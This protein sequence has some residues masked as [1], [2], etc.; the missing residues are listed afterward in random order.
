MCAG[1]LLAVSGIW[2]G[3]LADRNGDV[4]DLS[5]RFTQSGDAVTGKM[6]GDNE[7]TPISEGKISGQQMTFSV[8]SELNGQITTFLFT[9]TIKGDE[10]QVTRERTGG[11]SSNK[12]ASKQTFT[13]KRLAQ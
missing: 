3:Q 12:P 10:I 8:S 2:T 6:Y 11:T 4:R 9:G 13:L 5:F 7:S 1:G